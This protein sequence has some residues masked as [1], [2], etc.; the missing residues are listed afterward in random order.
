MNSKIQNNSQIP[1]K[2]QKFQIKSK[3]L[4]RNPKNPK[5]SCEILKSQLTPKFLNK[6]QNSKLNPKTSCKILK[7]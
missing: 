5:I 1:K 2:I 3:N 7:S 6:S 4:E